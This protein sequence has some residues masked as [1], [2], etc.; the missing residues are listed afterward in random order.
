MPEI[1][2]IFAKTRLSMEI[3]R[4]IKGYDG[5]YQ[6]SNEGRVKS[7]DR[8]IE[9]SNG[10]RLYKGRIITPYEKKNGYY[11]VDLYNKGKKEKKFVHKLV[12]DTFIPN[13]HKYTVVDHIDGD[14]QNNNIENLRWCTQ[15]QNNNFELYRSHQKNNKLK[16]KIVY[17][18]DS[19]DLLI[20]IYPSTKEVERQMNIHSGTVSKWCL[21]KCEDKKGYKWSYYPL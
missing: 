6:V 20:A 17:M 4:D 3:W 5:L 1:S 9:T 14:K 21:G 13:P 16:S 15:Q 2:Y 12:G 7:V 19:N 8:V 11:T 10:K 18:Y